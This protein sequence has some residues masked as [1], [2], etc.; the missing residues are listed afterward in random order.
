MAVAEKI[1][2]N[3]LKEALEQSDTPVKTVAKNTNYS[4]DALYAAM[5][6]KRK[7]PRNA[8]QDI[9]KLNLTACMAV[10]FEETHNI[11]FLPFPG[12]K[13]PQSVIQRLLKEDHEADQALKGI[14][15]ALLD[16]SDPQDFSPEDRE[17]M[18]E[19]VREGGD[20][21]R[22]WCKFFIMAEQKGI[23][24]IALF[25]AEKEKTALSGQ[26]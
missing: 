6:G 10:A 20:V 12:D 11:I 4:A 9:A 2:G 8:R 19:A 21:V 26:K 18:R 23:D 15:W 7:I 13:H 16:K 17:K 14:A 22:A 3:M 5:A 24:I 25:E 1:V